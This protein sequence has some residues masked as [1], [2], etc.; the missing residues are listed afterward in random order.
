MLA[1]APVHV[2]FAVVSS[3]KRYSVR[4]RA[5]TSSV[6]RVV[7]AVRTCV[8]PP[9]PPAGRDEPYGEAEADPPAAPSPPPD[10]SSTTTATST[11]APSAMGSRRFMTVPPAGSGLLR[12]IV[13]YVVRPT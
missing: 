8:A 5:S 2:L 13:R 4:P 1:H 7:R 10:T 9:A 6:P 11:T 12:C 3:S